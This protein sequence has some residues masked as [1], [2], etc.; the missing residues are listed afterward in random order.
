VNI[1]TVIADRVDMNYTK[2]QLSPFIRPLF[3]II[4]VSLTE[5]M[6]YC[7]GYDAAAKML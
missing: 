2:Q 4:S 1:A 6:P 7:K 3:P 5:I